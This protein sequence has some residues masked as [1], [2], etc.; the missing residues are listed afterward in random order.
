MFALPAIDN[1]VDGKTEVLFDGGERLG[2]DVLKAMA[3]VFAVDG[4]W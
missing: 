2:Q 1:A 3:L 4:S